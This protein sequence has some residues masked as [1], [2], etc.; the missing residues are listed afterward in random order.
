MQTQIRKRP[1]RRKYA[2]PVGGAFIALAVI[3]I[4]TVI[5]LSIRLTV[6]FL[7]ND[8]EKQMFESFIRPVVMFNPLPFEEPQS[9]DM[10]ELLRYS[11]WGTLMSDK[12]ASYAYSDS[13][14]LIIPATDLDVAAAKLFGPAME[15]VH[16][17]FSDY[18][19]DYTYD[20]T[21]NVYTVPMSAQLF[22]Y[23]PRVYEITSDGE[24]LKLYVGYIP[25]EDAWTADYAGNTKE[26][27]PDKY[28]IYVMSKTEDGYHIAKVQDPPPEMSA[29][30]K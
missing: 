26:P 25:P 17:S 15:L 7:D 30:A 29:P 11:M 14:D 1:R 27:A 4:V 20:E 10:M 21:E 2:A 19:T 24:Y 6:S 22:V 13:T 9:V 18:E 3:G 8:R 23:T 12:R 16:Q 5:V 28:M